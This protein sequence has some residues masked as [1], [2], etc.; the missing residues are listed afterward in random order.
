[1]MMSV[2]LVCMLIPDIGLRR[3][4]YSE[5]RLVRAAQ[6]REVDSAAESEV[7]SHP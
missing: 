2:F 1:M 4:K 6:V 3:Q 5:E 7:H